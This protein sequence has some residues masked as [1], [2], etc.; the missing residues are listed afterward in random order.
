[1]S[2]AQKTELSV[3]VVGG[4]IGGMATAAVLHSI[5]LQV[6]VFEQSQQ[7]GR[8]RSRDRYH[9]KQRTADG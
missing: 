7:V 3:A 4:G 5:G 6:T 1:M 9:P 8:N 2:G